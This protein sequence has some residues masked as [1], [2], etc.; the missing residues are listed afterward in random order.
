MSK[1]GPFGR[2]ATY[3]DLTQVPDHLIAELLDGDLWVSPRPAM[4]HQHVAT[5]LT[6]ELGP[7]FQHGKGGPGGW[8][9]LY[10]PEVHLSDDVLVPDLA[11]WRLERLEKIRNEAYMTQAPHWVCEIVSPSTQTLD[12]GQKLRVYA[13]EGV[14]HVWLIDPVKRTLEVLRLDAGRFVVVAMLSKDASAQA[15]PFDAVSFPLTRLWPAI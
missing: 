2:A 15:E 13:R 9:L 6:I 10:E 7:P 12:R 3:K 1:T 5:M 11:A 4:R 14:E 8:W